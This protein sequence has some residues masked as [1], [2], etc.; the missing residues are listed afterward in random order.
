MTGKGAGG[1]VLVSVL[2]CVVRTPVRC[3][4]HTL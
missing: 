1:K 2:V 3:I 4:Y